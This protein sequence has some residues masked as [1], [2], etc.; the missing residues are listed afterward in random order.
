MYSLVTIVSPVLYTLKH[1][2][3]TY[4]TQC[5]IN[6]IKTVAGTWPIQILL[7]GTFWNFYSLNIF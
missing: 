2:K 1:F 5:N 6:V 7:F 4:D 3:V